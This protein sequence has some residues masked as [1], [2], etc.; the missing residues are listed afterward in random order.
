MNIFRLFRRL[1][2]AQIREIAQN[3][4]NPASGK[5]R[6]QEEETRLFIGGSLPSNFAPSY[7]QAVKKFLSDE[8]KAKKN[9]R[10]IS[11]RFVDTSPKS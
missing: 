1:N 5:T 3:V 11:F 6:Q 8:S 9:R 4:V 2:S 10:A 7:V